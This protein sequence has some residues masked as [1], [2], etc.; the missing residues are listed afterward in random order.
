MGRFGLALVPGL[1][2]N[3]R[4]P[5]T[6]PLREY[7]CDC[8]LGLGICMPGRFRGVTIGAGLLDEFRIG[9]LSLRA[10]WLPGLQDSE[11]Y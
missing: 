9:F 4:K 7:M 6:T 3:L 11:M 1:P 5:H 10:S 8:C 2:L